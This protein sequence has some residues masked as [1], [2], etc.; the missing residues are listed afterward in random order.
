MTRQAQ[1]CRCRFRSEQTSG[2]C[3]ISILI[4]LALWNVSAACPTFDG[5]H[6][7]APL[8]HLAGQSMLYQPVAPQILLK[9]GCNGCGRT[10][11]LLLANPFGP[12]SEKP[13]GLGSNGEEVEADRPKAGDG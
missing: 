2:R 13:M 8:S 12:P 5:G 4:N 3:A 10:D 1:P 6:A 9:D 7:L 11:E